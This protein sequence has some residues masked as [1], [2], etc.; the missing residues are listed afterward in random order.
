VQIEYQEHLLNAFRRTAADMPWY[1]TLLDENG[2]RAEQVVDAASFSNL[3]PVLTKQNTFDRFPLDQLAATTSLAGL[4]TVLTS[5]GY[6]GRFSFG[7]STRR[8]ASASGGFVDQALDA[9]FGVK[10]Q[11]TLA[12]NCLPM[13]VGFNS[14]CMTMA[15][16]SVREDMAVALVQAF[17]SYYEQLVLVADPLFMKRLT[18]Y[19]AAQAVDWSRHR[20]NV[21]LGEEIFGEH[22]REYVASC[23]GLDLNRPERGR[24]VSSFGVGELGLHLCYETPDTIVLRRAAWRNPD[25]ARDLLGVAQP[26]SPLPMLLAFNPL[27]IFIE[28]AEPDA[29][30]YGRL[31]ISML[32]TELPIPLLRYQ[33]GDVARLL[34]IE[35]AGETLRRQAVAIP[36]D[37]PSNLIALQGRVKESL[38]NGSHVGVYKDAL[39]ADHAIAKQLTGAFRVIASENSCAMH[40]QLTAASQD[41]AD[42]FEQRLLHTIPEAVRPERL[43]L[44]PYDRFPFGMTVDYERKFPYYVPGEQ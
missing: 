6:G 16:T 3:C 36:P 7:L 12:I 33:T 38:P 15:T 18:D 24:I 13:G 34:D 28:I 2:V 14:E 1:R 40:V 41:A 39:Y 30:G 22:F 37:M 5:S 32:D 42:S 10:S 19:A 23:L 29:A 17:G 35:N 25:L 43:V 9:A 27:R 11:S 4:A 26:G 31:T 21:V 20:V 44:W 8:Q